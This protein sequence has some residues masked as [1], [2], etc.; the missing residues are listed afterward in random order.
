[1]PTA[2]ALEHVGI[3]SCS[4]TG[5]CWRKTLHLERKLL[6]APVR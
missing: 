2:E 5:K 3:E 4:R 6:R 1:M